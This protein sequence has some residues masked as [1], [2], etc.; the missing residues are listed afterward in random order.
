[1]SADE[2]TC[3]DCG[4]TLDVSVCHCGEGP[5]DPSHRGEGSHHFAPYNRCRCAVALE[6]A[7]AEFASKLAT[8]RAEAALAEREACAQWF[9][10]RAANYERRAKLVADNPASFGGNRIAEDVAETLS[11]KGAQAR[12][13]ARTIRASTTPAT[14]STDTLAAI[15]EAR[16]LRLVEPEYLAELE[17]A[18]KGET[19]RARCEWCGTPATCIVTSE[20]DPY[21]LACDEHCGHSAEDAGGHAMLSEPGELLALVNALRDR[22]EDADK[23]ASAAVMAEREACAAIARDRAEMER[24]PMSWSIA[25]TEALA[26]ESAI[27][28]RSNAT[29]AEHG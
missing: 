29:K 22:A 24:L 27:R 5:D 1:M 28:A 4:D 8:A 17:A 9:D 14:L 21:A 6:R 3:Q 19:H 13:D 2:Y 11:E 15:A 12:L 16:G 10:D 20:G 7:R 18:A 26:I 25:R 23:H